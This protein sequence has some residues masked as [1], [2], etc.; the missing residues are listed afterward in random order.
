MKKQGAWGFFD[1]SQ[2]ASILLK[3]L[4][5]FWCPLRAGRAFSPT[6]KACVSSQVWGAGLCPHHSCAKHSPALLLL[7]ASPGAVQTVLM[8]TGRAAGQT[9]SVLPQLCILQP[10][11][12][13]THPA[14]HN[15]LLEA[16]TEV[17]VH[18]KTGLATQLLPIAWGKVL[19]SS[20]GFV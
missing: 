8:G 16:G 4:S 6:C 17:M 14:P 3:K 13:F 2:N 12:L 9:P 1:V 5:L 10:G 15:P 18:S 7:G 19:G 20:E 11:R